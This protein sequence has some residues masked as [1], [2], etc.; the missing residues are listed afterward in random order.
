[1]LGVSPVITVHY[2]EIIK[3]TIVFWLI[4]PVIRFQNSFTL[5]DY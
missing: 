1:M 3:R 5:W 2:K 4:K